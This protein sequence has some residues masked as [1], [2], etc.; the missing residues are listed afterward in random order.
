MTTKTRIRTPII[1]VACAMLATYAVAGAQTVDTSFNPGAN[2]LVWALAVQADGKITVN[3]TTAAK[4]VTI[5][6]AP[7]ATIIVSSPNGGESW[8]VNT[9][10]NITWTS[11]GTI[12]NVKI[13]YSTNNGTA[14]T[15][16]TASTPNDGS[17]PWTVPYAS[18]TQCLVRVSDASDAAIFDVSNAVFNIFSDSTEP[19]NDSASAAVLPLGTTG[20]LIYDG[21]NN[22]DIDWYKFYV[23]PAQA[24]RD[25]K[26][27]VRV[28]S[29][30]P[31][32]LPPNWRSDLDF[33]LL[34]GA[35]GVRG[36]VFGGSDNETL[37]LPNVASGWYY[38]YIGY[39]TTSYA[40]S[41]DYARYSVSLETGTDF[42]LG[43]LN[44]RVVDGAGQG[45][46]KVFL[47]LYHFPDNWNIS[48]PAMTTGPGGNFT[49][50]FLPGTYDLNFAGK[51]GGRS[52][53][54][55]NQPPVNV[56]AEY[57]NNKKS[58][59]QADH[60]GLSAGQT[61]NLGD[62]A[63]DIGAIVS[64][65][66]T[67]AGGNPLANTWVGS[68]DAQGFSADNSALTNTTGDYSLNGVEIGGAKLRFSRSEY[69]VEYYNDKPTF[70]SGDLLA[71]QSSVTIPNINAQLTSGGSISGTVSNTQG[72]G[73]SINVRLWSV[74]D[75]TFV[76]AGISSLTGSGNFNFSHVMP[77]DYKIYFNSAA[78]GFAPEW[79]DDAASFAQATVVHVSEGGTT[80][81][82]NAW[83]ADLFTDD[84]LVPGSSMIRAAHITELRSRIN[85]V[86]ARYGL[87]AYAYSDPTLT[88]G[89][90]VVGALHIPQ[91]RA[92]LQEAYDLAGRARPTYTDSTL[93]PG[94]PI[95]AIHI[96]ELRA[97]VSAIE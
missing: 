83:L 14:W 68:Q 18:S 26:V 1:A 65:R 42:G 74:L 46:E 44:G 37:Y 69:A 79:Y 35:L 53:A 8:V 13:E 73:L 75:D 31:N 91:M 24:G 94:M 71:T 48:F 40:D 85:A 89:V 87:G 63:L 97:A 39:C 84:P 20:N 54:C 16:V 5:D 23:P 41:S 66:V 6:V 58:R 38:I 11:T 90:S 17:H 9:S 50:A 34:D 28:T 25:L 64:G 52:D 82:I 27:N 15:P 70:G 49:V 86:R 80:S 55:R 7:V 96:A 95:R 61:V 22:Q 81:G 45:I 12:A 2:G 33:E 3:Y 43:Y 62:V 10:Q 56:V 72:H 36:Q 67:D 4:T 78:A 59:S 60:V 19:N 76:R 51:A 30:Y 88:I 32:P 93:V 47:T 92:A 21:G 57:Y 77:G 29:P